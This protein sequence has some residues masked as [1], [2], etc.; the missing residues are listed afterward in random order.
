MRKP[1][2]LRP[3]KNFV[4]VAVIF[5]IGGTAIDAAEIAAVRDRN[6]QVSDLPAEFVVKGHGTLFWLDATA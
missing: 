1:V 5:R 2:Q 6:A 3:G 4:V